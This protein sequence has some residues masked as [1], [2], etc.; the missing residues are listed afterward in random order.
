MA[1]QWGSWTTGKS[2]NAR[3]GIEISTRGTKLKVAYYVQFQYVAYDNQILTKTGD[4]KGTTRYKYSQ[5]GGIRHIETKTYN[6]VRGRVYNFGARISGVYNGAA[7]SVSNVTYRMP[8]E[9]EIPDLGVSVEVADPM[10]LAAPRT[11]L[12]RVRLLTMNESDIGELWGFTGGEIEYVANRTVR[13]AGTLTIVDRGQNIDWVT[14][15]VKPSLTING[16]TWNLGVFVPSVPQEHW[17]DTGRFWTVDL[18]DKTSILDQDAVEKTYTVK[19]GTNVVNTVRAL[20]NSAGE[21]TTSAITDSSE[22]LNKGLVWEP[23]TSKLRIINDLL[24]AIGYFSLWCDDLGRFRVEPYVYPD[25][26]PVAWDFSDQY[27]PRLY[28]SDFTREADIYS[29][30]N[31]V[32][33]VSQPDS[34]DESMIAVASNEDPK[35][36]FSYQRRGRW[37]VHT[38]TGVEVTSQSALNTYA[39]KKLSNLSSVV[40]TIDIQHAP[41]P[42]WLNQV[43]YFTRTPADIHKERLTVQGMRIPLSAT[44]LM[45]STLRETTRIT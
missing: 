10:Q 3:V 34:K 36:E 33:A 2:N 19:A 17:T 1:I 29:V 6:G 21:K 28:L 39:A 31:R 37:I 14:T 7:P 15:R 25:A 44:E 20:I 22:T 27:E 5:R 26:R 32:V 11:T 13:G 30:P 45:T 35:S 12:P 40:A 9:P 41:V 38:E 23:G 18:L 43:V 16:Y 4:F 42:I 24:D 8:G